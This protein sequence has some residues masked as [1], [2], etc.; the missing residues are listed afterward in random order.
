MLADRSLQMCTDH[1][2]QDEV[3]I[4]KCCDTNPNPNIRF[5]AWI[6]QFLPDNARANS[7]LSYLRLVTI[8]RLP[9]E[10]SNKRSG[11]T[12]ERC[13]GR[14][15]RQC[16]LA[17]RERA[18]Q[19][20]KSIQRVSSKV[21]E[22]KPEDHASHGRAEVWGSNVRSTGRDAINFGRQ[23]SSTALVNHHAVSL[24]AAQLNRLCSIL[25]L[26]A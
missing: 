14:Q 4:V 3:A 19:G 13:V 26:H 7:F 24:A 23:G 18:G 10:R 9:V 2:I 6:T 17:G 5:R 16:G 12:A 11:G 21:Q 15:Y 25:S 22:Q 20:G 1:M 8:P